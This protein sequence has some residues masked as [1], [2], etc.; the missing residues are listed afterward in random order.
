M[1][2]TLP[3]FVIPVKRKPK[4]LMVTNIPVLN[5]VDQYKEVQSVLEQNV[6]NVLRS[7]HYILG[8]YGTRL[9]NEVA[10]ICEAKYGIGV[11]NGTDA[12][13]LAMMALDITAGDEVI[14]TP[15]TFAA[16]VEAILLR[17]GKPVFVDIDPVTF[18]I[19]VTK[20]EAAITPKTKVILP[21]HLYGMPCNMPAIMEIAK[22][23]NLRVVEDNAQG[24]GAT[25][26]GKAT[27][28]YGDLACISF[29][30]TKNLGAAGDAG[31]VVANDEA[32]AKRVKTIRAHGSVERYYHDELGVNSRLDEIQAAVL[33]SKVSFLKKWNDRRNQIATLYNECLKDCPNVTTPYIPAADSGVT[34]VWHQY[35]VRV[36]HGRQH[37]IDNLKKRGIGSMCYYPVPLHTQKAFDLGYK[38]GDFP[39]AEKAA[40]EVLSL[41]MYPEL[42]DSQ[43]M[44]VARAVQEVMAEVTMVSKVATP[45]VVQN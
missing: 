10:A 38:L 42:T 1:S 5:L 16:T 22:K 7:G 2:G 44:T 9:E 29:Y 28:S 37:L 8:E 30:P 21:V 24:I 27:G 6:L 3:A 43:A 15:F 31:M 32:L 35:T 12:L 23:H 11:A 14:T 41:P 4:A 18:N 45:I 34:H 40:A 13:V 36:A 17:G 26:D 39:L 20:I 19:D 33:M 25:V